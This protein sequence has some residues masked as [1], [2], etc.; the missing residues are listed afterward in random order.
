MRASAR[1]LNEST[2]GSDVNGL[3]VMEVLRQVTARRFDETAADGAF[4]ERLA[5][6]LRTYDPL[7]K[8]IENDS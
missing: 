8:L 7:F 6:T 5:N 3:T 2:V 4:Q 1:A